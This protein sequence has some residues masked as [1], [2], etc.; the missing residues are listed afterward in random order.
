V[1]NGDGGTDFLLY[2][3]DRVRCTGGGE[4]LQ[5][6]RLKPDSPTRRMAAGCCN[7]AMFLE[8]SKGHWLSVYRDRFAGAVP[9]IEVRTMTDD[10]R[11]GVVLP[12][13]MPNYA[14]HSGKFMWKLL[15]AWIAMGLRVPPVK[16][17]PVEQR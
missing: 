13:D 1:L 4:Q 12:E 15:T 11:E 8:F 2:R 16:G 6:H 3:K 5:A 9:P 14:S 17:V 10:R 7:S